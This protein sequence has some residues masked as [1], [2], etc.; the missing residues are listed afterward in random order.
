MAG[1]GAVKLFGCRVLRTAETTWNRAATMSPPATTD[2][3]EDRL[4]A[5][6]EQEESGSRRG[7]CGKPHNGQLSG[8]KPIA[9]S[10]T[11]PG[12]QLLD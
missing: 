6:G 12:Q 11:T 7:D 5:E 4:L 8:N 2:V 1:K 10:P 3:T 9:L